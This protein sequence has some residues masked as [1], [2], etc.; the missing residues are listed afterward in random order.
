MTDDT[1]DTMAD[2]DHTHPVTDRPFGEA[3]A[4]ERGP[5]VAADGGDADT[6]PEEST[7][8]MADVDHEHPHDSD[9]RTRTFERGSEHGRDSV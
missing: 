9:V 2:V 5:T 3:C 7:E 6:A 8:T 1:N 4:F